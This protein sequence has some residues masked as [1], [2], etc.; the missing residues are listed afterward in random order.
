LPLLGGRAVTSS[1]TIGRHAGHSRSMCRSA[2]AASDQKP[3]PRQR[4]IAGA[5]AT[6]SRCA[7]PAEQLPA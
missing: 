1:A 3:R 4:I 6:L 5:A 2:H 7:P